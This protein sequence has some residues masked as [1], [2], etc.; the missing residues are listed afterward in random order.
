MK[1]DQGR[2]MLSPRAGR[3]HFDSGKSPPNGR[4]HAVLTTDSRRKL[5]ER[6]AKPAQRPVENP[7]NLFGGR[8][9]ASCT[10]ISRIFGHCCEHI[11]PSDDKQALR[12]RSGSAT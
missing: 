12:A 3:T 10:C 8:S 6:S 7:W 2:S 11:H 4:F 1:T 5:T 9:R